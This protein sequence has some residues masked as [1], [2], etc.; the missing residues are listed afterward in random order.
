MLLTVSFSENVATDNFKTRHFKCVVQEEF[1]GN[2]SS[3]QARYDE[4]HIICV[5]SVRNSIREY[6]RSLEDKSILQGG[7]KAQY[8]KMKGER[9]KI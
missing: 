3:L 1:N 6:I 5:K 9:Y 4:L 8:V 2:G 7:I